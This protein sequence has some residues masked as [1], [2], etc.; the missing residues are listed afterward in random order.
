M[1]VY[2]ADFV[3]PAD[4]APIANGYVEVDGEGRILHV[5]EHAP[6]D[7]N[8]T[9]LEGALVPGLIN[10]HCHLELSH[11]KGRVDTGTGLLPFLK[12]VVTLRDVDPTEIQA[13]IVRADAD[14]WASGI[15]AVGDISNTADTAAVKAA[16]SI[17]YYTFVEAFDFLQGGQMAKDVF[18]KAQ[19]VLALHQEPKRMV[20][21]APYTVSPDLFEAIR[22]NHDR[23]GVI[24]IHNQETEAEDEL[25]QTNTGGFVEF[26]KDF[27]FSLDHF[28]AFAKTSLAATLPHLDNDRRTLFVHNT[29]TTETDLELASYWNGKTYWCSCPNANLYIENRLPSYV[30]WIASGV[31]VT[32]GTDSLTS[33]WQLDL[34]EEMKSIQRLQS[35]IDTRTLVQWAT[36]NG[37]EALGFDARLGSLS[38][39]KVPGLV[40]IEGV[41]GEGR[42]VAGSKGR[43]IL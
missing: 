17:Q 22:K 18:A 19:S 20:P 16:S 13:A 5:S 8:V 26:Y 41:D 3:F 27:G 10:T 32:L 29:Q 1:P 12:A 28:T 2:R 11:M 36:L 9:R 4:R 6:S 14:M 33:N 34:V 42:L 15:Q 7:T 43:R 24:S 40:L 21:H 37:A 39:G 30:T 35:Y 31:T 38:L 23:G 25:F